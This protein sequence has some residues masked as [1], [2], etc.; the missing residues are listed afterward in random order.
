MRPLLSTRKRKDENRFIIPSARLLSV[1]SSK[2]RAIF[3][4]L[5]V[6]MYVCACVRVSVCAYLCVCV[7]VCMHVRMCVC[8]CVCMYEHACLY[9][10]RLSDREL[11][12]YACMYL[13]GSVGRR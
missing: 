9:I 1:H 11:V 5:S 12:L 2:I 4:L 8:I 3:S 13:G 6:C 7:C 10:D